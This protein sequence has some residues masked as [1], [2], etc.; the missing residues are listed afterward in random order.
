MSIQFQINRNNNVER[1]Y[2]VLIQLK[3]FLMYENVFIF[4]NKKRQIP[5]PPIPPANCPM[6]V[7]AT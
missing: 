1:N 6:S 3:V 2:T 4:K 7:L 5:P